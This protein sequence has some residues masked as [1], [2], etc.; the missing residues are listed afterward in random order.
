MGMR[1]SDRGGNE[2]RNLEG[3]V[4]RSRLPFLALQGPAEQN[5]PGQEDSPLKTGSVTVASGDLLETW[6]GRNPL[7]A[8][9]IGSDR[10]LISSGHK[11][12][13]LASLEVG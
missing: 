6:W 3:N 10:A 9:Y 11:I 5:N 2:K 4:R 1:M 13:G 7:E 8:C 12:S